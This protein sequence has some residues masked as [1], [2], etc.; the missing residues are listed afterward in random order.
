MESESEEPVPVQ[1]FVERLSFVS[2]LQ[3]QW[4]PVGALYLQREQT[5][6]EMLLRPRSSEL[7]FV[8][9]LANRNDERNGSVSLE[10]AF[11]R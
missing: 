4:R 2:S 8:T 1:T 7:S 11:L 10:F 9:S 6:R 5:S 3:Q